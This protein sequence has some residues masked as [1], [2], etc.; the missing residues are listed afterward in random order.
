MSCIE[1]WHTVKRQVTKQA[2]TKSK[3]MRT[4]EKQKKKSLQISNKLKQRSLTLG[5]SHCR[6]SWSPAWRAA[7]SPV[8]AWGWYA[9]VQCGG[10]GQEGASEAVRRK[11]STWTETPREEHNKQS[12][13]ITT[14][15]TSTSVSVGSK[16][17]GHELANTI[18]VRSSEPCLPA[19]GVSQTELNHP[20]GTH[21]LLN[22][23]MLTPSG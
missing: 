21:L 16:R 19:G 2:E 18:S 23:E 15:T 3:Y 17:Q 4:N 20:E 9:V 11:V 14:S 10:G 22:F 13:S 5:L 1:S 8:Q 12:G 6:F 7:R